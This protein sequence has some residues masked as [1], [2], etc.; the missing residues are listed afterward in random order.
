MRNYIKRLLITSM[1]LLACIS[2][3]QTA[4]IAKPMT[5]TSTNKSG[6]VLTTSK[7]ELSKITTK[8]VSNPNLPVIVK[9]GNTWTT[10]VT[11]PD[12][13]VTTT[14]KDIRTGRIIVN[15][16]VKNEV[17]Q[18]MMIGQPPP[19]MVLRGFGVRTTVKTTVNN[20][21]SIKR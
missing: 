3:G 20:N 4:T 8:R 9:S 2:M 14:V 19:G 16:S 10:T 7:I 1:I 5:I 13:S 11:N 18:E 17:K 21:V 15:T 12:Q 6:V